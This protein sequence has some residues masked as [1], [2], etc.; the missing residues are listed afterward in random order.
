MAKKTS[1]KSANTAATP[2]A[3][4]D[5]LV[6]QIF[7]QLRYRRARLS[8]VDK[9]HWDDPKVVPHLEAL[10]DEAAALVEKKLDELKSEK[11]I[12]FLSEIGRSPY[13][14]IGSLMPG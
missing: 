7:Q 8:P 12:P 5:D 3:E 9:N 4:E 2:V 14:D 13:V 1:K 6:V 10:R 11:W